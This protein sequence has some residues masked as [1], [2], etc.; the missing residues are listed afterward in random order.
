MIQVTGSP[1]KF[2][3]TGLMQYIA[4]YYLLDSSLPSSTGSKTI[5]IT[6]DG[7][8]TNEIFSCVV[9]YS[10]V[11]QT[12]PDQTATDE[13]ISAGNTS[14]TLTPATSG[15]MGVL[16]CGTGGTT[17]PA[18]N[19]NNIITIQSGVQSS[20]AGAI[21]EL[22]NQSSQFTFGYNNLL[23][24]EGC[25]GCVWSPYVASHTQTHQMMM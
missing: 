8:C 13:N 5:N 15:S 6:L 3:D 17:S 12:T 19:E 14:V 21:G 22:L 16:V 2:P 18:G 7:T 20:A 23:L 11:N 9:E 25:I 1:I 10:G 4:M 24:R